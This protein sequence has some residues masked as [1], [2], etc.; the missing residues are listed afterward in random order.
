MSTEG[1][2]LAVG[3]RS[4]FESAQLLGRDSRGH[5]DNED[6]IF[7]NFRS[8]ILGERSGSRVP[9]VVRERAVARSRFATGTV[10][11]TT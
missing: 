5:C 4:L 10:T 6:A 2:V 11:M 1:S 3:C 9:L 8:Y 7:D